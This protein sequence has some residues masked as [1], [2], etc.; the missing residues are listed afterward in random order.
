MIELITRHL[1]T[2]NLNLVWLTRWFMPIWID[3]HNAKIACRQTPFYCLDVALFCS[4]LVNMTIAKAL[5]YEAGVSISQTVKVV[6]M[7]I[8]EIVKSVAP[9]G[10]LLSEED[11]KTKFANKLVAEL[12]Y[13]SEFIGYEVPVRY[14]EGST[15]KAPKHADIVCYNSKPKNDQGFDQKDDCSQDKALFVLETKKPGKALDGARSQAKFY[16]VWTKSIFYATTNGSIIEFYEC[17][18]HSADIVISCMLEELA[19]KWTEIYSQFSYKAAQKKKR[20]AIKNRDW[21]SNVLSE[22]CSLFL[23]KTDSYRVNRQVKIQGD[24]DEKKVDSIS[25]VEEEH[26]FLF[27]EAGMGKSYEVHHI[28]YSLAQEFNSGEQAAKVPIILTAKHWKFAYQSI[29]EGIQQELSSLLGGVTE[30]FVENTINKYFIIIDGLDEVYHQRDLLIKE[31]NR[32]C[33]S[34]SCPILCTS[35]LLDDSSFLIKFSCFELCPLD[36]KESQQ[37]LSKRTAVDVQQALF[38]CDENLRALLDTPLYLDMLSAYLNANGLESVPGNLSEMYSYYTDKLVDE[39]KKKEGTAYSGLETVVVKRA[40]SHFAFT[41]I[42]SPNSKSS[43]Q[44]IACEHL[45]PELFDKLKSISIGSGILVEQNGDVRFGKVSLQEFLAAFWLSQQEQG[46]MIQEAAILLENCE[47]ERIISL[48]CGCLEQYD[49]QKVVLDYLE[50]THFSLYIKCLG[51]RY[52]FS[53]RFPNG[54]SKIDVERMLEQ[55]LD[56]FEYVSAHYFSDIKEFTPFW[57]S[58]PS[59]DC[60][61]RIKASFNPDTTEISVDFEFWTER[62]QEKRADCVFIE[63]KNLV[64]ITGIS[65]AI[66]IA[67]MRMSQM[68]RHFYCNLNSHYKSIDCGREFAIEFVHN[69]ICDALDNLAIVTKEPPEMM[70]QFIESALNKIPLEMENGIHS[71]MSL[72]KFDL[73][74]TLRLLSQISGNSIMLEGQTIPVDFLAIM[75]KILASQKTNYMDTILPEPDNFG[76]SNHWVWD[77]YTDELY[78]SWIIKYYYNYQIAYRSFIESFFPAIKDLMPFYVV[79]PVQHSLDISHGEGDDMA[80]D[81]PVFVTWMP[82]EDISECYPIARYV[83]KTKL[84]KS[85]YEDISANLKRKLFLLNRPNINTTLCSSEAGSNC[86][87]RDKD[88]RTKVHKK[89]KSELKSIFDPR[90]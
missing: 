58:L 8:E 47:F 65:G 83:E 81:R 14:N 12:G 54:L 52:N 68:P 31:I 32:L 15:K 89:V 3:K 77:L 43:L 46:I 16:A 44:E 25:L 24:S 48:L 6:D 28:A 87:S 23:K 51:S 7:K 2:I 60:P 41:L 1:M 42:S 19:E 33:D 67:S 64:T 45:P 49:K 78:Q 56:T 9:K 90:R 20:I 5:Q 10:S 66:P 71:K 61:L 29:R 70:T 63:E 75:I 72:R 53:S 39:F 84:D 27:A 74:T 50:Q 22:Y 85:F 38:R 80:S 35:R 86:L 18:L 76:N 21:D 88:I 26:S 62:E 55:I 79:G 17:T 37:Y 4:H 36:E 82:K 59:F 69:N 40:L 13:P 30:S 73:P 57:N 11:V 34:A